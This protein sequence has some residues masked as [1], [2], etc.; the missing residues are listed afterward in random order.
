MGTIFTYVDYI[1]MYTYL[2]LN[3]DRFRVKERLSVKF[4]QVTS[5]KSSRIQRRIKWEVII[6][7]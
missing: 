3:R 5:S 2:I 7:I 6:Y 1:K 4:H